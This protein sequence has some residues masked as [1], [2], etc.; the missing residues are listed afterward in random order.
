ML[1]GVL[2]LRWAVSKAEQ[3]VQ[4]NSISIVPF[5][6]RHPNSIKDQMMLN[7]AVVKSRTVPRAYLTVLFVVSCLASCGGATN[8]GTSNN[9]TPNAPIVLP[10]SIAAV[11]ATYVAMAVRGTPHYFCDCGT[12][13]VAGCIAGSD[14]ND[15]LTTSTPKQTIAAAI[16]TLNAFPSGTANTVALCKGG[17]FNVTGT[18]WL[19]I[20]GCAAGTTCGD[21]REFTPATFTGTAKPV[22]NHFAQSTYLFQVVN[23]GGFRVMNIRLQGSHD[24]AS[25]TNM[26]A[27]LYTA[28]HDVTF[29]NVEMDGFDL[30][31]YVAANDTNNIT[32]TG[33]T[34]TNSYSFGEL[35]TGNNLNINYNY[36]LNN[37]GDN[38]R[39]H[40]I[41][42]SAS[43]PVTNVNVIGNYMTGA[44]N[45][46]GDSNATCYGT[47]IVGHGGITGLNITDNTLLQTTGRIDG[48]C[49]GIGLNDG[50][51]YQSGIATFFRSTVI[52]RNTVINTGG[53]G[54]AVSSCP[55]CL[56]EDNLVI[57][58]WAWGPGYAVAG[59]GASDEAAAAGGLDDSNTAITFRNNTIWFG[60]TSNGG[61]S[62]AIGI[63]TVEGTGYV[64]ANNT[65]TYTATAASYP[66][67]CFNIGRGYAN[68]SFMNNNHC[69]ATSVTAVWEKT[70]GATRSAWQ[71]YSGGLDSVSITGA[72]N[73]VN[74]TSSTGYDFHPNTGSPLLGAGSHANAP[75][76]DLSG[77]S[78]SNPP[79]IGAYE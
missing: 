38:N 20:S 1:T 48:G 5:T 62:N 25:G 44:H 11:Q 34:I 28:A 55:S 6:S 35:G 71:T 17:A 33:S 2:V 65:I 77:T 60:P 37:G 64:F 76:V 29:G 16:S 58:D 3:I 19:G 42:L 21:L 41:Y 14:S 15:G 26:A 66:V 67:N 61:V 23:N 73:F 78:F 43:H 57:K 8:Q 74:A 10:G 70:H 46:A 13:H 24:T 59:M 53:V 79:A 32:L 39:D 75:T 56:I 49:Y 9:G 47:M 54:I 45:A 69:N 27:F 72:P 12:G 4:I 30:P 36:W 52:A 63:D 50:G 22:I 31:F 68:V 51:Y 40:V 18:N 7:N